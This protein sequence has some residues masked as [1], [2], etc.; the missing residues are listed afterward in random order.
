VDVSFGCDQI[1]RILAKDSEIDSEPPGAIE[2]PFGAA[3]IHRPMKATPQT[4][5]F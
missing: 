5:I 4:H 1:H 3:T 2:R